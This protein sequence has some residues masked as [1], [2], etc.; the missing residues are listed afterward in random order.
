MEKELNALRQRLDAQ[1]VLLQES[2]FRQSYTR[3]RVDRPNSDVGSGRLTLVQK[4]VSFINN[5]A[6]N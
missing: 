3:V 6:K 5:T 2:K 1:A 4:Y